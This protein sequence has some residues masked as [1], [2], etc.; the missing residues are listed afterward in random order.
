GERWG[1]LTSLLREQ[2]ELVSSKQEKLTH[3]RRLLVLFDE[4]LGDLAQG[5]WAAAEILKL[6]PGDR[7]AL[8]RLEA[9]LERSDD[10]PRLVQTLE[11]HTRYTA[12]AEEKVNLVRRIARI[13]HSD[14]GEVERAAG[15]W[16]QLGRLAPGDATALDALAEAYDKLGKPEDPARL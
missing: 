6:V 15:Y 4:R 5:S 8:T 14:L 7:E 11:Y 1:E 16:E 12:T 9:I 13:L 10:K 3:L 2:L